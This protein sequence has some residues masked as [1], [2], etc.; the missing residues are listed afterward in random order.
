[1]TVNI[2]TC[3]SF[4]DTGLVLLWETPGNVGY[5][6][7]VC[8]DDYRSR[9][10]G[11]LGDSYKCEVNLYS[12]Q[13]VHKVQEGLRYYVMVGG[14][15]PSQQG[16]VR[17]VLTEAGDHTNYAY[18]PSSRIVVQFPPPP[19]VAAQPEGEIIEKASEE[20]NTIIFIA[21][22]ASGGSVMVVGIY[23]IARKIHIKCVLYSTLF[24]SPRPPWFASHSLTPQHPLS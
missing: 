9:S 6:D 24:P 20:V 22:F 19:A 4:F 17:L 13:I 2:T 3:N 5:Y 12:S 15:D 21:V 11:S 7:L 16:K 23:V 8:N 1:M 10:A 18:S 14:T